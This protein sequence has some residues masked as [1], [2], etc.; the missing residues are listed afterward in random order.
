MWLHTSHG[1]IETGEAHV[2]PV[3]LNMDPLSTLTTEF[4]GGG[5]NAQVTA[6]DFAADAETTLVQALI[7]QRAS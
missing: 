5:T 3:D 2:T 1:V 4:L 7:G 6:R